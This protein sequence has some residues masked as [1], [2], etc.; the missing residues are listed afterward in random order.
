MYSL[1]TNCVFRTHFNNNVIVFIYEGI[2]ISES[3][4]NLIDIRIS[5]AFRPGQ[6]VLISTTLQ[7][8][9]KT[10]IFHSLYDVQ[11]M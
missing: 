5:I 10:F 3:I 2:T 4:H 9:V 1:F 11:P 6:F 8:E 7:H